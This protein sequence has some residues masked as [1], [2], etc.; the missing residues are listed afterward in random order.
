MRPSSVSANRSIPASSSN[1][2]G[3]LW[4]LDRHGSVSQRFIR[5]RHIIHDDVFFDHFDKPFPNHR[6][7]KTEETLR[8]R[9]SFDFRKNVPLRIQQQRRISLS[10]LKIFNVVRQDGVQIAHSVRPGKRKISQA[11]LVDQ[12]HTLARELLLFSRVGPMVRQD[13]TEPRSQSRT[14]VFVQRGKRRFDRTPVSLVSM[15][16]PSF[17]S[18]AK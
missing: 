2:V 18:L 8:Q 10:N 13:A 4:A 5:Q 16:L 7:G 6:V 9:V 12:R 17:N 3:S 11:I 14:G 1:N 15:R